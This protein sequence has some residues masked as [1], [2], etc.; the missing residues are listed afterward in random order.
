MVLLLLAS[1]ESEEAGERKTPV[2][3]DQVPEAVMKAAKAK[4]PGYTFD[5][6]YKIQVDGRD[7]FEVRG[8]NAQGE[9]H[10]VEVAPDGTILQTE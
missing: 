10:E 5:R 8:K 4:L 2:P 6:S 1:C 7:A 9:I 3:L